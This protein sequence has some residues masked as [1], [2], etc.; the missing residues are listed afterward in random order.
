MEKEWYVVDNVS[1]LDSPALLIYPERVRGNIQT[2]INSVADISNLRPHIKTHKSFEVSKLMLDAGIRKFKCATIAEAEMLAMAGA[3]DVLLAYQ[4]VG[5]K[6]NRLLAMVQQFPSTRFSCLIDNLAP[7][8]VLSEI[9]ASGNS[10]LPVFI[11]L[12]AGMNRTGILPSDAVALFESCQ[13]LKG[14]RIVGLHAYDGHIRDV[15]FN[16]RS[17][18]C[19]AVF[20]LI[21]NVRQQIKEKFK[22]DLTIVVGGTPTFSVHCKR[23]DAEC[24]PGTFIYWDKGYD[25]LLPEQNF[26]FAALVVSRVISKPSADTICIDLGHKSIASE[27]PIT[28]RVSFLNAGNLTPIGHSEEHMVFKVEPGRTYNVG[29]VL[30]GVPFHICPT[31]ALHD[32]AA[33]VNNERITDYWNTSSRTRKITI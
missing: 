5:P 17:K 14:I 23:K 30:Y 24:S 19:D 27:N 13:S 6:A 22:T 1:E 4:P 33:V 20:D 16:T 26:N 29:D 25:D 18:R 32:K 7:A 28:H 12:N 11:D 10:T 9:F 21:S 15:D 31:V 3:P 2:L 8:K